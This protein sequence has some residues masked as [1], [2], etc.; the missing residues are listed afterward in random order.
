MFFAPK[1]FVARRFP[2][3]VVGRAIQRGASAK[4][5]A[6]TSAQRLIIFPAGTDARRLRLIIGEN[7]GNRGASDA[8]VAERTRWQGRS[9]LSGQTEGKIT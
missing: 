2:T 8:E 7:N 3:A 1:Y 5:P 4:R 6:A 9:G